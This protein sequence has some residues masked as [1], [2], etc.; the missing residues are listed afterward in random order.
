[1]SNWPAATAAPTDKP[2]GDWTLIPSSDGKQR[3]AY[4]G[5]LLHHYAADKQAGD[6]KGDGLKDTA[7]PQT[8]PPS[9]PPQSTTP[10]QGPALRQTSKL[11]R[12][13]RRS[14]VVLRAL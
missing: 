3:W 9:H 10:T 14:L 11:G 4:K 13:P 12:T 8:A 7:G 1:M 6:A 5:H 2:S